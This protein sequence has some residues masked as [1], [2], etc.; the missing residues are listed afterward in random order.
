MLLHGCGEKKETDSSCLHSRCIEIHIV[1]QPDS[2]FYSYF[3][4]VGPG[5]KNIPGYL[6]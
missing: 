5:V 2:M 1:L 3:G 4:K 6:S